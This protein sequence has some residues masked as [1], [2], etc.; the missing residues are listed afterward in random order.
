MAIQE[1][2]GVLLEVK[3]GKARACWNGTGK[4]WTSRGKHGV[5]Y[6]WH[7]RAWTS[8]SKHGLIREV[9]RACFSQPTESP[10]LPEAS[11]GRRMG[12]LLSGRVR[13]KIS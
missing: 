3:R 2:E 11:T 9:A 5:C 7:G 6:V 12:V 8:R 1:Q 4:F 10:G 13:S